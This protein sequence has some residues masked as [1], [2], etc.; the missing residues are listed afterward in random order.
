MESKNESKIEENII[1]HSVMIKE[2]KRLNEK[3]Q[4]IQKSKDK[5]EK[6]VLYNQLLKEDNTNEE[7]IL[8]YLLFIENYNNKDF[9]NI[10]KEKQIYISDI[11]YKK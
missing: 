11:N 6:I 2:R 9:E 3:Y 4:R 1:G 5:N 8:S 7:Y 10:L